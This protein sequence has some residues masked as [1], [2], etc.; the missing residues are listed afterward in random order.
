MNS[1]GSIA[2]LTGLIN[3]QGSAPFSCYIGAHTLQHSP[4]WFLLRSN[5]HQDFDRIMNNKMHECKV[6]KT[7][8]EFSKE[9]W[10]RKLK[11]KCWD[12]GN[13]IHALLGIPTKRF[14]TTKSAVWWDSL[15]E[16]DN[17]WV[18]CCKTRSTDLCRYHN[19]RSICR[20]WTF[21]RNILLVWHW[22]FRPKT[23]FLWTLYKSSKI[24]LIV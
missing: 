21:F 3:D 18:L 23:Y 20:W 19:E 10:R 2:N 11:K 5:Q 17:N 9:F 14:L 16:L 13:F 24:I 22:H 1:G 15:Q 7:C 4:Q 6:S 12:F 8:G